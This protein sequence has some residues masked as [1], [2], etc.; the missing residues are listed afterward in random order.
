MYI[1]TILM[2]FFAGVIVSLQGIVN[3]VGIG[4]VGLPAMIVGLS[5]IQAIPSVI[6]IL[7]KSPAIGVKTSIVQGFNG[8]LI[9]GILGIAIIFL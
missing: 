2:A 5:I 4:S 9:A 8:Y 1:V 6:L 3:N 7:Y